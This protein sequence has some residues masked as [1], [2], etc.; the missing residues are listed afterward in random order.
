MRTSTKNKVSLIIIG[1]LVIPIII[2]GVI[3]PRL[4][5][6]EAFEEDANVQFEI[7]DI[8]LADYSEAEDQKLEDTHRFTIKALLDIRN[9]DEANKLI[10]PQFDL[11]LGYLGDPVGRAW[12]TEELILEPFINEDSN[13]AGLLPLYFTVYVGGESRIVDFIEGIFQGQMG[14]LEIDLTAYLGDLPVNIDVKL[15]ELLEILAMELDLT[16]LIGL[17]GEDHLIPEDYIF[18][19]NNTEYEDYYADE[20]EEDDK[21]IKDLHALLN[22]KN[23]TIF[24]NEYEILN[25]GAED[26]FNTLYWENGTTGNNATGNGNYTWE[27]W[28]GTE[29]G[30]LDVNDNTEGFTKSGTIEFDDPEGWERRQLIDGFFTM[31]YYYI[32]CSVD[33]LD[34]GVNII[35][36]EP[37]NSSYIRMNVRES[38]IDDYDP[39]LSSQR[40]T[41]ETKENDLNVQTEVRSQSEWPELDDR[42]L[43]LDKGLLQTELE[44]FEYFEVNNVSLETF[45]MEDIFE[46]YI[47]DGL[48]EVAKRPW[49]ATTNYDSEILAKAAEDLEIDTLLDLLTGYLSAHDI[50][51]LD[52]I[53]ICEFDWE[54]IISFISE[55]F[56]GWSAPDGVDT[57]T[58]EKIYATI[59][60]TPR[61]QNVIL[62]SNVIM[63]GLFVMLGIIFPYFAQKKQNQS[64]IF[65]DIKNL[66]KYMDKVK[67]EMEKGIT[68]DEISLLKQAA[69]KD[70]SIIDKN[71]E[72]SNT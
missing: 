54:G 44:L 1:A 70:K 16:E 18:L 61:Y 46:I 39:P 56:T 12:T 65:K 21:R 62:Y 10:V 33:D 26:T 2:T 40:E 9:A 25:F 31:E 68:E 41:K 59:Q 4:N 45:F 67:Q 69:F 15:G 32:R 36:G 38:Y 19:M 37:D 43:P 35:K 3:L 51:F 64:F 50:S 53:I 14:P 48:A 28:D 71:E 63:V 13:S 7:Y 34:T 27:Y 11:D 23:Q 17:E 29:W 8:Y 49:V 24:R 57:V 72:E 20:H 42:D 60:D 30:N 22:I 5:I 58:G 55:D 52:F 47:M 66:D 6:V